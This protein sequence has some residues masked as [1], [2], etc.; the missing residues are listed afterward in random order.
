MFMKNKIE[1]FIQSNDS[2]TL[3][4]FRR[5]CWEDRTPFDAIKIQFDLSPNEAVKVMRK[6]LSDKDFIRWR[7]RANNLGHLKHAKT[8]PKE[9]NR[10]KCSRERLDGSTKGY[11]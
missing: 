7:K 1:E 9:V 11:K 10:F 4:R 2:E 3:D 6:I 8:R 5:M